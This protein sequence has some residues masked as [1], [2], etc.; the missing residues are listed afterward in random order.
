MNSQPE[1]ANAFGAF[2]EE[3]AT[4]PS[5]PL[6]NL[7]AL[8]KKPKVKP[9]EEIITEI[10]ESNKFPSREARAANVPDSLQAS[11]VTTRVR[12]RK[13]ARTEQLNLRV[14]PEYLNKFIQLCDALSVTQVVGMERALDALERDVEEG[15]DARRS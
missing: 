13:I 2:S 1:R 10:S 14:T 3:Q 11:Q 7:D 5:S 9:P 8:L 12:R 15:R 4:E 6:N